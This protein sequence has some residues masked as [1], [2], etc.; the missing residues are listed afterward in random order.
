MKKKLIENSLIYSGLGALQKGIAFLLLPVYTQF[1]TPDDYGIVSVINAVATFLGVFYLM[2]L[3]G[4]AYR[5][6]FDLKEKGD[7]LKRF[8]GTIITFLLFLSLGITSILLFFGHSMLRPFIGD[9][10]YYPYM[11]FGIVGAAF[12]PIFTI[13]QSLLQARHDGRRYGIVNLFNFLILSSLTVVFIVVF[14]LKAMG[15]ILALALTSGLF[16]VFTLWDMRKEFS[17]GIDIKYLKKSLIYSLPIVPHTLTGW[18]TGLLDRL[19]INRFVSTAASG[20]YNIGYLFGGIQS[21]VNIAV[22]QAYGPWFFEEMKKNRT[23]K[24]K[25]FFILAMTLYITLVLWVTLFAKEA[26]WIMARGDFRESWKVVGLLSFG[27]FFSGYYYF[28]ANQLFFSERGT[29]YVPIAT[30]SAA[31]FSFILNL[32]LIRK[33]GIMGAAITML[34]T[35]IV[36]VFLVGLFARRIQP[37]DWD[38]AFIIKLVLINGLICAG[39]HYISTL[40][41]TFAWPVFWMKALMIFMGTFINYR[42][43][44]EKVGNLGVGKKLLE[45]VRRKAVF[46]S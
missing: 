8:W 41:E 24:V 40:P 13:Y 38:H 17:F 11:F 6:Y 5:Y 18:V 28:L 1:L 36:T 33:Y 25:R 3:N 26:M 23:E 43:C 44:M 15:P 4:A 37:V 39:S 12:L 34:C 45:L 31:L 2:G 14:K 32:V 21:F 46:S 20:I 22:N 29:R 10:K 35:S 30:V 19:L 9:I 16:L 7:E 42:L 27:N